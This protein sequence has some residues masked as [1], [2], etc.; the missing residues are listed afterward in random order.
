LCKTPAALTTNGDA[1]L[2][3]ETVQLRISAANIRLVDVIAGLHGCFCAF[4]PDF[5]GLPCSILDF[6][7]ASSM[8]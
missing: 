4:E 8:A 5:D 1:Q 2:L 3:N 7:E 6:L